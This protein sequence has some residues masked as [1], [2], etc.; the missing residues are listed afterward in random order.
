MLNKIIL[1]F[2]FISTIIKADEYQD[3]IDMCNDV[4]V[5]SFVTVSNYSSLGDSINGAKMDIKS[6]LAE[7]FSGVLIESE[8]IQKKFSSKDI[9]KK[10][11]TTYLKSSTKGWVFPKYLYIYDN[12]TSFYKYDKS[13]DLLTINAKLKCN[14][15]IYRELEKKLDLLEF[16][17]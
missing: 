4:R 6:S 12:K 10:E 17:K 9:Y 14:K 1:L 2:I 11:L 16:N 7:E 13:N 8:L 3:F 5:S 15:R